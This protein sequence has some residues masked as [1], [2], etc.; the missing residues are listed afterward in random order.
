MR[1]VTRVTLQLILT[2]L[3]I[4]TTAFG[5]GLKTEDQNLKGWTKDTRI[6]YADF[7]GKPGERMKKLNKEE[8]LQASAQVGLKSILDVPK[9]KRDRGRL[10]EKVYV[11]PFFIKG[12]SVTMTKDEN[13]LDK[14]RLYFDM[15]ELSARMMR[16]EIAHLKDSAKTYGTVWIMFSS[17]K[18]Y[19]CSEFGRMLN[20]YTYEV[21]VEKKEGAYEKWRNYID[22]ELSVTEKYMTQK[23]DC[24][25]LLTNLPIDP[26][27]EQS[28]NMAASF[29]KC[30]Q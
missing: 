21:F 15:A 17:I 5:Q 30:T 9:R 18:D 22:G 6:T 24:H 12:T 1:K 14:Q 2:T 4:S 26:D 20:D 11:A 10:L 13:E 28:E 16:K 3:T 27:Y 29:M 8:G 25:R 19:Y 7:K 23:E